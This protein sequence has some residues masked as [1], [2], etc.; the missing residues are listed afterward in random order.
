NNAEEHF[1]N[2]FKV[3]A[4]E[5][6]KSN[7]TEFR[8][9]CKPVEDTLKQIDAK[10]G[11]VNSTATDLGAQLSKFVKVLQKPEV[12]GQ[13]GEM[14]LERVLELTGMS[15]RCDF[16]SQAVIGEEGRLRPDVVV[17]LPGD[18][19]VAVDAKATLQ[20][21]LD[22]ADAP[23]DEARSVMLK[24]FVAHVR[25]R[26]KELANKAYYQHLDGSPEFVVLYLPTEGLFCAALSLDADLLE[27]ADGQG[28][29][30]AG[31]TTLLALFRSVAQGWKQEALAQHAMELRDLGKDLYNRLATFADHIA[32]LRYHLDGSVG[33]YN[34]FVGSL[35]RMVMP[36][37]RKFR[38]YGVAG[39]KQLDELAPIDAAPRALQS[40]D[41]GATETDGK[42][43]DPKLLTSTQ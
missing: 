34:D 42:L 1:K 27:F 6:L 12:R 3:L 24:Q 32:K 23:D 39:N 8:E 33:A 16:C 10:I 38:D 19:R 29:L 7:T 21:F 36:Q 15:E 22:M 11:L 41:M 28:V 13:Y 31:P 30:L 5:A 40:R 17:N 20:M 2:A 9:K 43:L 14:H 18:K 4:V 26:I 25:S 37:A 35:E